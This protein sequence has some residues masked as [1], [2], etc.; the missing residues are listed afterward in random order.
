MNKEIMEL[1]LLLI[2]LN[3]W[4]E[5]SRREPGAKV[6]RAW[7]NYPFDILNE[8]EKENLIRQYP[9]SVVVTKEGQSKALGLK[10]K[11]LAQ[12]KTL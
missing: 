9:K 10:H 5:D 4:V 2:Y 6:F 3:G 8:L 12:R 1:N 11:Y 7:E